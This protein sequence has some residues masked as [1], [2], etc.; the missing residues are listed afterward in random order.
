MVTDLPDDF[1]NI[2]SKHQAGC[3]NLTYLYHIWRKGFNG[4]GEKRLFS[5]E[6]IFSEGEMPRIFSSNY[7]HARMVQG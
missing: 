4:G 3:L 2:P 1:K 6:F 7:G 5:P